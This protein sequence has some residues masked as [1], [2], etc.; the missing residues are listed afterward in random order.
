MDYDVIPYSP[1]LDAQIVRLQTHLW[2][3]DLQRNA[4]Y[5]KWKYTDNPFLRETLIQTVR[6]DEDLVG[7]RGMFGTL[8]EVD[9]G[10][11]HLLPYADDFVIVPE[12]RNR[13]V[14]ARIM[15]AIVDDARRR[16]YPFVINLS[17]GPVTFVTSLAAGWR[18]A[19]SYAPLDY[20]RPQGAAA[21]QVKALVGERLYRRAAGVLRSLAPRT[22]FDQLDRAG[23]STAPFTVE[24]EPRAQAMASLVS[25][26]PWDGRIRHVRDQRYFAWRFRNPLH[27]YRF[28]FAGN[29]EIEGYLVLQRYLSK[30]ADPHDVNIADWEG[31]DD[32]V[33]AGLLDAALRC[34]HLEHLRTWSVSASPAT[35]GLLAERGFAA[36]EADNVRARSAGLLLRR[37]TDA[38]ASEPWLLGSRNALSISEWDL[39]MI[40]S[41]TA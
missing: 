11:Q 40:Y 27:E 29:R 15:Q 4:A 10:Q 5:L 28:L 23:E 32:R 2:G 1:D 18:S 36:V 19:G 13:G 31:T 22:A 25:R 12:H 38:A 9:D 16:G 37:L 7:M 8:W 21:Q 14:A 35:T 39:R 24:R 26:L 34:G 30:W 41:M 33:R 6:H 20:R 3:D 17:A